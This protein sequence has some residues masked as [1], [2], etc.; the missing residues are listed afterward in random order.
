MLP[1][2]E[3]TPDQENRLYRLMMDDRLSNGADP[4]LFFTQER[5]GTWIRWDNRMFLWIGDNIPL[6]ILGLVA[7]IGL[8]VWGCV[9]F[10]RLHR[11]CAYDKIIAEAEVT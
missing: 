7:V 11:R 5:G 10:A 6:L 3:E 1:G 2:P 9:A 8:S 4:W